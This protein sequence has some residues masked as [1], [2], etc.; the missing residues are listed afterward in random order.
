MLPAIKLPHQRPEKRIHVD[1]RPILK[2]C[3]A[4]RG[5]W[6]SLRDEMEQGITEY[7]HPTVL[8]EEEEEFIPEHLYREFVLSGQ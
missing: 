7:Y 2:R 3:G 5:N 6:G 8:E 4:G 1:P